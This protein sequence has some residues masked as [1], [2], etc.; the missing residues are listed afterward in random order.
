MTLDSE[1][2]RNAMRGWTTG[3]A[4][5]TAAHDGQRF[6]MTV[7]SFTSV[8]LE[9]PLICVTLK[10]M[11]H[12]YELV[13]RSG[14]FAMTILSDEQKDLSDRFAGK[15]PDIHDRFAGL[16]TE[17]LLLNAPLIKGGLAFFNCRV[18]NSHSVGEN[19]LVVAEVIAARGKDEGNP[20]VYHNRV[21]WKL[22]PT[23]S[24][25]KSG[26]IGGGQGKG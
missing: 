3:V 25:P 4:I 26:G 7:N 2:L 11:T 6:G 1:Q 24:S 10:R 19:A 16:E 12:T 17:T 23:Q 13:E 8:S 21:Y 14:E 20:L 9:P 5:V 22:A 18:V 15:I